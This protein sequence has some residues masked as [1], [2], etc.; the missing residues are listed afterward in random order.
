MAACSGAVPVAPTE[1]SPAASAPCSALVDALPHTLHGQS[2]RPTD[3][4][5]AWTAA[6]GDPPI[7]LRCGVARP[8]QLTPTSDTVEVD[9]VAWLPIQLTHGYRF[10]TTGRLAYVEVD[11]PDAYAPEVNVLVDLAGPV[12]GAVPLAST[13]VT[14]DPDAS[15]EPS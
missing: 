6:W 10:V 13:S 7:T 14:A 4:D 11:V 12:S 5:S 9:G 3:P 2:A 8:P 1:P 15:P